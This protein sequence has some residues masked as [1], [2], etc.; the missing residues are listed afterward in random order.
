MP[1]PSIT[2][3]AWPL[4]DRLALRDR[5][6]S[7]YATDRGYHDLRHL[8][9]VL[10]RLDELGVRSG[11]DPQRDDLVVLLAAW[12]HDAVY[13]GAADDEERSA[14]L[15]EETLADVGP[16]VTGDDVEEVAR[17]VR[18]TAGHDP[19]PGDRNGELLC[20]ADLAILAATPDRYA[21][22]VADVRRDF[23]DI[24]DTAFRAG[25]AAVLSELAGRTTIFRTAHARRH[26]EQR[27]QTNLAAELSSLGGQ[28]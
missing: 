3:L 18:L 20:D 5:L 15:A 28:L 8:A 7:A 9:E 6:V 26:W 22:Y 12:F 27:A 1:S 24:D 14:R 21:E 16:P 25:R 19:A 4:L 13:A 23:A 17:L 10:A 2:H 11:A